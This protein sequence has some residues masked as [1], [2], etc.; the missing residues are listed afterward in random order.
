MCETVVLS[1]VRSSV[2]FPSSTLRVYSE[3]RILVFSGDQSQ[4]LIPGGCFNALRN[5]D[6][7]CLQ[8]CDFKEIFLTS[9]Y[10]LK[11]TSVNP[12]IPS[13]YPSSLASSQSHS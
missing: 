2:V 13:S 12:T 4:V 10:I 5:N 9:E 1:A 7:G 8:C 3:L 6:S 11:F